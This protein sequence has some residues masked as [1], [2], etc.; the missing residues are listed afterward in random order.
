MIRAV[1]TD[2]EG[3]TSS[4]RFVHDV[5]FPYARARIGEFVRCHAEDARVV[6]HLNDVRLQTDP[7]L[8]LDGV[9]AQLVAWIDADAKITPLK[10]LQ[11][12]IWE[13]GYA[14][15]DFTGHIYPDAVKG[16]ERWSGSGLRLYVFSSGSV[17]AQQ[18]LFRHSDAGDLTPLFS[19]YY[20]TRI[21][22]KRE[23]AAYTAIAADVGLPPADFLF[24]SD[25]RAELDAAS[26]AGM[27]T[28]W[29][30]RDAQPDPAAAHRQ[31]S[32]FEDIDPTALD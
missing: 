24:L 22:N 11:G 23:P 3:T 12:M 29:L 7:E 16:L 14:R 28:T 1:L 5:L 19:G 27:Q 8:D 17:Q 32:S 26:S 15:G 10:A 20:D 30:V 9:I 25:I 31:V 4:L 13:D 6:P 18:L 21:G 2:I